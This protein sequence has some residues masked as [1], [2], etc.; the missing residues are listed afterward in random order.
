MSESI[1]PLSVRP[2][3]WWRSLSVQITAA[4]LLLFVLAA[5]AVGFS[6]YELELRKHDYVILNL[7]GQ[8]RVISR[9]LV[10]ESRNYDRLAAMG[11][12]GTQAEAFYHDNF[13]A[14]AALFGRIVDSLKRRVL[15][16]AL[17]GRS[18]PLVCSWD[19]QS[20][21]QLDRTAAAWARFHAGLMA[22]A[23]PDPHAP[24]LARVSRYVID[25]R[26]ELTNASDGLARAFQVMMEGKLHLVILFNEGMLVLVAVVVVVLLVLLTYSFVRP[27]RRTVAGFQRVAQGDFGS[28]LEVRV[29]NEIGRMG[30]TFNALARRLEHLFRLTERIGSATTLDETLRFVFSEFRDVVPMDWVGVLAL[31]ASGHRFAL[32]RVFAERAT[33]LREGESFAAEGSLLQR[34]FAGG[35]PLH[36]AELGRSEDGP[37]AARLHADG[38]RSAL[39]MPLAGERNWGVLLVFVSDTAAAY[40]REHLELL[41]NIG[42]QVSHGFERTVVAEH[43][44]VSAVTGLASLAENRDPETGDHLERMARYSALIAEELGRE[45]PYAGQVDADY[46]RAILRFAP[47]HDI[48]KVGVADSILLKPARLDQDEWRE[49]QRHPL[50]GAE[51]LRRCEAQMEAV[52]H[53]VFGV[54]IEIAEGHHEKFDGSGYPHGLAGEAI[55]LAARIVALADVFDALTSKRPYKEAWP[56]ERAL[57]VL[58]EERGR[59]FDPVVHDAMQRALPQILEVYEALKHVSEGPGK[60]SAETPAAGESA[61]RG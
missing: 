42:G 55:P 46:V 33:G 54:G 38:G 40:R 14:Q 35:A 57:A 27:L 26:A 16:P 31:D 15:D 25:H 61:G 3:R 10:A 41:R 29:D 9:T 53:S 6:V 43:L 39:L 12:P 2:L 1:S 32:D 28:P 37:F 45:G 30:A 11:M 19:A 49:M 21:A 13:Q 51:V 44:V 5:A 36:L 58:E 59:H 24:D 48:G 47:M 34:V 22:A 8:L 7:A 56:V 50:I 60:A 18:D 17:T 52:G 23:G 20:R 4:L